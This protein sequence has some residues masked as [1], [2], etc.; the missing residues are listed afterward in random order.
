MLRIKL[1]TTGLG[2]QLAALAIVAGLVAGLYSCKRDIPKREL[3][4]NYEINNYSELFE[5]FWNGINTN[6][7][8]WDKDPVDWDQMYRVYKPKFEALNK[9]ENSDTAN[10]RCFQYM[11]DMT[12]ELKDGQY[13]LLVA[14]G[15]NFR[16]D[17]SLYKSYISFIPKLFRA[18]RTR[19]ALPDTLF[20]YVIQNNY[21]KEFDYGIYRNFNTGQAF[22]VITGR[23]TK[24]RKNVLYT[25]LNTFMVKEAYNA[26]YTSRP[27]RPV[28]KNFFDNVHK[29]N[30][31]AVIIDLRNNRGGNLEDV[32]FLVG[33][34]TSKPFLFGYARYKSGVGRLDYTPPLPLNVKPQAGATDFKK[35]IVILVDIYSAAISETVI[36][37]FKSLPDTK[38]TIVGE[39]TYGTSGLVSGSDISMNGGSYAM[40]T[41]G[42]VRMSTTALQ[43]KNHN[44]N[45]NGISP[46]FEVIYNA[47]S[48]KQM[49]ST[50]VDIQ[51]EKAINFIN[52]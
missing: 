14:G 13:A 8:F 32:D 12:K 6:Y 9:V 31:D 39:H 17:D 15:G 52:Q 4:S 3:L 34:F 22:Q 23:L 40:G 28:I 24:G 21:L 43:D 38:V 25:N 46:D 45:F 10:N 49:Q 33:Q 30:C 16:F 51:M 2:R 44:F 11:A 26:A 7:L 42:F 41:F 29:S 50:G 5:S 47:A 20:D 18:Q 1:L 19:A 48:I 36:Q 37:A 35:P 27:P